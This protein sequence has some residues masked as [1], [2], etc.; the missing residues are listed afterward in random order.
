MTIML[1]SSFNQKALSQKVFI[2]SVE[3]KIQIG[4]LVGNRN[5]TFGLKNI[6]LENLQ[7]LNYDISN[8]K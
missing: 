3:N 1:M 8:S 5:L 7:D 2:Q 4:S 6:L